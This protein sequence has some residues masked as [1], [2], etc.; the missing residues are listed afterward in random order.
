MAGSRLWGEE[1]S[2]SDSSEESSS[3][4]ELQPGVLPQQV[5]YFP[6]FR[7]PLVC[8]ISNIYLLFGL[9]SQVNLPPVKAKVK[10]R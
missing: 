7:L 1:S 10:V 9:S 8:T 6:V 3:E 2:S 4:E 5:W